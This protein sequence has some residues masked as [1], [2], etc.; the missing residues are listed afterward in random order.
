MPTTPNNKSF[1]YPTYT[2]TPDIPRDL[3]YLAKDVDDYLTAHPGPTGPTGP[4]GSQGPTGNTGSQ[5]PTGAQ[6]PT[7]NT[8]AQGPTGAAS[9]VAG[10]QGIQ[11]PTGPTGATGP[12]GLKGDQGTGV[13]VLGSYATLAA[14]Q[15]AHPTGS[16]GDGYLIGGE[17]YVWDAV[18]NAWVNVGTIQGPQGVQGVQGIQGPTGPT[19]ATG[20]QGNTGLT[21]TTGLT[22]ATGPT[23]PT[24]A[25][26]STGPT[27][28]TGNAA[29]FSITSSTP[30]S[31]PVEG[32]G[33]FDS[34]TGKEYVRY[35]SAWV[36]VGASL[37]G[38]TGPTGPTGNTGTTG[39]TGA[40]GAA[41]TIAGPTGATGP[42]GPT[43]ATGSQGTSIS[44]KG[45]VSTTSLLPS[46][47]NQINDAYIVDADGDLYVWDG[48]LPWHNVGQIVGPTGPT[49]PTGTAGTDGVAGT[50]GTVGPTGATGAAATVSVY[51]T[52]TLSP[53]SSAAV[54]NVGTSSAAQFYFSVP[55]GPTGPQG[56]QGAQGPQG[57]QGNT[58]SQGPQGIQ[59]NTGS[60]GATGATGPTGPAGTVPTGATL[61]GMTFEGMTNLGSPSSSGTT[62]WYPF[63][64]VS[65]NLG[66]ST[67][68]WNNIYNRVSTINTSDQREKKDIVSSDLGLAFINDLN[69]VSYRFIVGQNKEVL[70]VNGDRVLDENGRPTYEAEP[71]VRY[72]YGL[73]S[74]EVKQAV[75]LH[76][77]KDFAGWILYDPSDPNSGQGLRY[78]EFIAPL[79]KAV[80]ELT[81]RVEQ[82]EA[83]N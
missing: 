12:T 13:N 14:L 6:G 37:A 1:R 25:T 76:T 47:G 72:H 22:G 23:G 5:G 36:E 31:N 8:G 55:Q 33:W 19:G 10:P 71:G 65:Y 46:S 7:G 73:V 60:T 63:S 28:S 78:G 32:Q 79:I 40:T 82:L 57:L 29:V 21:G 20:S 43:G 44:F 3:S 4:T 34:D 81:A 61:Y 48:A 45:S 77:Q 16:V 67:Y 38:P 11:G 68:K 26:G 54:T 75:D 18:T 74:Q 59:G 15:S 62:A 83:G 50:A 30:P 53:G 2:D 27:G 56:L 24:G 80:Q 41:S 64:D 35:G 52:Q 51:G 39:A 42:T 9:T 66:S 49:G 58:G 69:P 17:L 70:D